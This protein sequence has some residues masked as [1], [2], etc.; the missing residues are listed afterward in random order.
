MFIQ[1]DGNTDTVELKTLKSITEKEIAEVEKLT[2]II[3][4]TTNESDSAV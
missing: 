3:G 1:V 4:I 2:K